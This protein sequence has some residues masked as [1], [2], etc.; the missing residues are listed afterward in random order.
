M[1]PAG[2]WVVAADFCG[3]GQTS[4]GLKEVIAVDLGDLACPL[5]CDSLAARVSRGRENGL[6]C[7]ASGS[8]A[9]L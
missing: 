4:R 7:H 8:H 5:P 2:L 1:A 6:R 9:D 3:A